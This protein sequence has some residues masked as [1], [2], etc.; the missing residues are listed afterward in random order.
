MSLFFMEIILSEKYT[1]FDSL[2]SDY[3]SIF[4][5]GLQ[6]VFERVIT[7]SFSSCTRRRARINGKLKIK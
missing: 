2:S 5:P 6:K 1:A 7:P 3:R 4:K